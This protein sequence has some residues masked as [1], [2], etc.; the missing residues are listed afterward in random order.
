MASE[1]SVKKVQ[2]L[3]EERKGQKERVPLEH[4][5]AEFAAASPVEM[6]ARSGVSYDDA[7]SSFE[8]RVL[9]RQTKVSWPGLDVVDCATGKPASTNVRILIAC[10]LLRGK[11]VPATGKYVAYTETPWGNHY[12]RAFENRCIKRLARTYGEDVDGFSQRCRCLGATERTGAD[13]CFD[14]ELVDG[15]FMRLS[16]WEGDDEFPANAQITFSDNAVLA[17]SAEEL[18][19]AGD[20]VCA[21]LDAQVPSGIDAV[22]SESVKRHDG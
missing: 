12:F 3:R 19:V 7:T 18:A 20:V 17:F 10:L 22:V 14:I 5:L 1:D 16:L 4:Y 6:S 2:Q 21:A 11:L 13:A 8:L 15:V 9:G